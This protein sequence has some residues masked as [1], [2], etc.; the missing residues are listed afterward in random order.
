MGS[1][2]DAR[3]YVSGLIDLQQ[4]DRALTLGDNVPFTVWTRRRKQIALLSTV[5]TTVTTQ[6]RLKR[7]HWVQ[8]KLG[9]GGVPLKAAT[10]DPKMLAPC[11]CMVAQ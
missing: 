5:K 6:P 11:L 4:L 7:V 9:C 10:R 1:G 3:T 8:P 2:A